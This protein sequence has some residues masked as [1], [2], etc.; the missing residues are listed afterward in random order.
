MAEEE[1]LPFASVDGAA[2]VSI[3]VTILVAVVVMLLVLWMGW[4]YSQKRPPP[5]PYSPL[6]LRRAVDLPY[7]SMGK[8]YVFMTSLHEYD[9]R[10]FNIHRAALCRETGRIYPEAINRFGRIHVDWTFLHKRYPGTWVSWGSLTGS[11]QRDFRKAHRSLDGFQTEFSCD[12][13]SPRA[14]KPEHSL[15]KPGPLYVDFDTKIAMGWKLVP[16]TDLEVLVVQKP[17]K[18]RK[19]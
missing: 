10:M 16:G 9:N 18:R 13:P 17:K 1:L 4:R 11:Q 6:P 12:N 15:S 3:A 19:T 7:A 2:V 5:G 8:V 14:I